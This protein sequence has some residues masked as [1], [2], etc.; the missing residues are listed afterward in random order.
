MIK[1]GK[2]GE[3]KNDME[4]LITEFPPQSRSHQFSIK[5]IFIELICGSY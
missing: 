3:N 4:L 5:S 2:P 1:I